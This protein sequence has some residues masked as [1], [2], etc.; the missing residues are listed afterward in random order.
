V[1]EPISVLNTTIEMAPEATFVIPEGRLDF[2]AAGGFQNALEQAIA[3]GGQK[4]RAVVV[5]CATLTYVSSAGLRAFL[6]A[7]RTAK[8]SG[9]SFAVCGLRPPVRE[10]FDVS[11]FS[12][13]IDE[14]VDRAAAVAK[15]TSA[16]G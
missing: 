10:V 11:G 2:D 15:L 13:I 7:A 14:Y 12:R 4:P 9:V 16:T 1:S 6:V 8:S 3:G 5:D